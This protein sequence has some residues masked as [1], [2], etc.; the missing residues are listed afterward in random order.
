[1]V[2]D[3]NCQNKT[4]GRE[5]GRKEGRTYSLRNLILMKR[6]NTEEKGAK[7]GRWLEKQIMTTEDLMDP[8]TLVTVS[9]P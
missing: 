1:M 8:R 7:Q 5:G 3:A 2:S 9:G 6:I 4:D